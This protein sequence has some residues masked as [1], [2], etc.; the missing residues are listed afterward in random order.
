M[1]SPCASP[2]IGRSSYPQVHREH[3]GVP[4]VASLAALLTRSPNLH[5][6]L[7]AAIDTIQSQPSKGVKRK[8]DN[9]DDA[10]ARIQCLLTRSPVMMRVTTTRMTIVKRTMRMT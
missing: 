5:T 7:M 6:Q 3:T 1:P 10:L 9:D 8:H 2:T 4:F